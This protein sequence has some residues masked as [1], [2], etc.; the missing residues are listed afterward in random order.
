M[1]SKIRK[2]AGVVNR[3]NFRAGDERVVTFARGPD[4][5]EMAKREERFYSYSNYLEDTYGEK[6]YR[7]AVDAGF[8]CPNRGPDRTRPGCSY[9]DE[10]GAQAV[11]Q[12]GAGRNFF[13]RESIRYQVERGARF[14]E[15]RYRAAIFLL[16]FQAFSSTWASAETLREIYDYCLQLRPFRELIVST[17]PDCIN[18]EIA[19]L[20]ASYK[21]PDFDVWVELGLQSASNATLRGIN[22]G[23]TAEDFQ[24]ASKLLASFGIKQTAHVIFGLPGEGWKEIESTLRFVIKEGVRGIKI[25]NLHVTAGAPMHREYLMGELSLPSDRRHLGYV[26]RALELLPPEIIIHRVTTDTPP[27]RLTA[28]VPFWPKGR[29]YHE[30]RKEMGRRETRQGRLYGPAGR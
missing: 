7:V 25:H 9:C 15:E 12:D 18:R 10:Y 8:S 20:L 29:F 27:R 14:M 5:K 16:Y 4:N 13:N 11:Y 30:L 3:R 21:R 17:R 2:C 1:P 6:A 19:S 28:P 22:R 23:H 24:K 26:I